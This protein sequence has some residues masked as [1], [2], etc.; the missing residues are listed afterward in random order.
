MKN[1]EVE[2]EGDGLARL[3]A[4]V[5]DLRTR[6]AQLERALES[7][8]VIEQAKGILAERHALS[9]DAAFE[10]L[11]GA[12]RTNG[13]R[14]HRLARQVVASRETP[15]QVQAQLGSPRAVTR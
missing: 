4:L 15:P 3:V 10:A 1:G 11:R 2:A 6:N 8:V 14:L 9:I 5:D 7:R 12:A 13:M